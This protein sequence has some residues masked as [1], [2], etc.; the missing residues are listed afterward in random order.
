MKILPVLSF[1]TQASTILCSVSNDLLTQFW[2]INIHL[3]H[4]SLYVNINNRM[5]CNPLMMR[6]LIFQLLSKRGVF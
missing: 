5:F 4:R 1:S 6:E 3:V 2:G